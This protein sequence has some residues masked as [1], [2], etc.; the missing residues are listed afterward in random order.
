MKYILK[1]MIPKSL[2]PKIKTSKLYLYTEAKKLA[3]TSKRLDICAA[4]V[5]HILHLSKCN[6]LAGKVCL[7]LGSGWTLSHSIIFHLLGAKKVISTDIVPIAVP[8]SLYFSINSSIVSIIRDILSPFEEHH[9]LRKRLD[10]LLAIKHF[11]FEILSKLGIEYVAPIDFNK[12][13]I[14]LPLD[15]I[16]SNSVFEHILPDELDM[17]LQ[18]LAT[19]L[20]SDGIMIHCI[21]LED[22]KNFIS[23]PFEFLSLS[24]S[25][26]PHSFQSKRGNR[27][28]KSSWKIIFEKI[29][30][31]QST[32]LY[33]WSR[34]DK[35]LPEKIDLSIIYENEEDIR[36]SHLGVLTRKL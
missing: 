31:T 26:Y 14:N 30:N 1:K 10:N 35:A 5:A 18:N 29:E 3:L 11:N 28:R 25:E 15:F 24:S 4:Q 20:R 7:E 8:R 2:I 33:E 23:N 34:Y 9:L 12:Q 17:V 32:F 22:H 16:Y 21:H 13:R 6:S 19:D 27:I 36:T